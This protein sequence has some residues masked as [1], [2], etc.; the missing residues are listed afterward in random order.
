MLF[1]EFVIAISY[2][3]VMTC[4]P[5]HL[6]QQIREKGYRLT[7]QRVAILNALHTSGRH[8]SATEIYVLVHTTTH[9]LTEPTIYRTLDF[10]VK[11]KLVHATHTGGGRLV[12]ELARHQ[13]H[14]MVCSNCGQEQEVSH[15][16][17]EEIYDQ[18]EQ[19]TGYRL[20]ENHLTFTGLCPHC[21][22]AGG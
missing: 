19:V 21:K 2:N 15:K 4:S 20:T 16:Q 1:H 9:G 14:H 17:M 6:A 22:D 11:N 13:H 18:L 7:P 10:L 3:K 5:D 12:Y 8:L